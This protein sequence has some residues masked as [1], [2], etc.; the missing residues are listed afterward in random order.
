MNGKLGKKQLDPVR[1]AQIMETVFLS[2]PL[3]HG[4]KMEKA[5]KDCRHAIDEHGR[6]LHR[7]EKERRQKK[8]D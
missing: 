4:E 3:E 2:Y 5:M 6:E 8:K 7:Q 1:M